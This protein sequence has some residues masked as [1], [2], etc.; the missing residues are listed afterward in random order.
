MSRKYGLVDS[1]S[2]MDE[3]EL[4]FQLQLEKALAESR[5]EQSNSKAFDQAV[6]RTNMSAQEIAFFTDENLVLG[7]NQT[8]SNKFKETKS[9]GRSFHVRTGLSQGVA[10]PAPPIPRNSTPLRSSPLLPRKGTPQRQSPSS[11]PR[12]AELSPSPYVRGNTSNGGEKSVIEDVCHT[13]RKPLNG[14]HIEA[15]NLRYHADCFKCKKCHCAITSNSFVPYGNPKEPFHLKCAQQDMIDK[16]PKVPCY[17]CH[18]IITSGP[19]LKALDRTYHPN[20][21][22]CY[23]CKKRIEGDSYIPYGSPPQPL[24]PLCAQQEMDKEM[25]KEKN[26]DSKLCYKCRKPFSL[27]GDSVVSSASLKDRSYHSSC[28]RCEGCLKGFEQQTFVVKGEPPQPYHERCARE[29]FN[30]RCCVCSEAISGRYYSHPF[31][32]DEVYCQEI[33]H[34]RQRTCCSCGR[35]EPFTTSHSKV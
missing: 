6:D 5:K 22:N 30:P 2:G 8:A 12:P 33:S 18:Q 21:F 20:C 9:D 28:F 1:F 7:D 25:L 13:C 27:F 32:Q 26:L 3:E 10:S 17:Q 23:R 16:Q 31:F 14:P 29:L 19:V 11:I 34:E 24:H 35:R 4:I 15:M